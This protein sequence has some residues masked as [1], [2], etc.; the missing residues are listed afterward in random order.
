MYS[1]L[2]FVPPRVEI[3]RKQGTGIFNKFE[4]ALQWYRSLRSLLNVEVDRTLTICDGLASLH[5]ETYGKS[6]VT[7]PGKY[8]TKCNLFTMGRCSNTATASRTQ[9]SFLI[10][11][12]Y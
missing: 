3:T 12:Q 10:D 11:F 7:Q 8:H 1:L 4:I 9:K 2:H 6:K 5:R